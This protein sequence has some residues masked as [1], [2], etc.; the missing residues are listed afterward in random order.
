MLLIDGHWLAWA[1]GWVIYLIFGFCLQFSNDACALA[2]PSDREEGPGACAKGCQL[3]KAASAQVTAGRE[4]GEGGDLRGRCRLRASRERQEAD[5]WP[6]LE[7]VK[8]KKV[9]CWQSNRNVGN[10]S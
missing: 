7:G 4:G 3:R 1:L 5:V 10:L 9:F 8:R 2:L 6:G